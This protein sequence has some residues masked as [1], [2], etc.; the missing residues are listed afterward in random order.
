M[1]LRSLILAVLVVLIGACR[2]AALPLEN[3]GPRPQT[4]RTD[5]S[6]PGAIDSIVASL[7]IE[8]KVAQMIAVRAYGHFINVDSDPFRRLA[9]L[10]A[11]KKIGGIVMAQG[12]VYEEAMLVNRLQRLAPIPLLIGAD[13]ER[14][15][16]MR[17]RRGTSFPDAMAVGATR[18]PELAYRMGLA[19]AEEARAIG[20]H[21]NYAPVADINSNP[22]NPVINTRSFGD[23]PALVGAMVASFVKGTRDGGC[24]ATVKHFPGHG[25]TGSDSH[26]EL[27]TVNLSRGRLDSVEMSTFRTAIDS[28]AGSVMLAHLAVPALDSLRLPASLSRQMIDG[29][30]RGTMGFHGLAVTD[31]MG[32]QA[33]TRNFSPARAALLA[34]AAGIDMILVPPDEDVAFDAIVRAVKNGEIP[35]TRIDASVRRIL[36]TKQWLGLDRRRFVDPDS[37]ALCVGSRPHRALAKEICRDAVTLVRNSG[38]LLPLAMNGKDRVATVLISDTEENRSDVNRPGYPL[39]SEPYGQYFLQLLHRRSAGVEAIR[40]TPG[41]T[42]EECNAA[43]AQVRRADVALVGMFIKVHTASGRIGLPEGLSRFFLQMRETRTPVVLCLFGTPYL[44]TQFPEAKA[45]LCLYGDNEEQTE[46][47]AEALFGEIPL[48]GKLPVTLAPSMPAGTGI[49]LPQ[50]QLRRDD[51]A[52]AGF[53]SEE[54][55][56]LDDIV[57]QAIADSAFPGAQVAVIKDGMLVY[58]RWFGAQTYGEGAR[59]V[60]ATTMYDCASLTKVVATTAALMRLYDLKKFALDDPVGAYLPAFSRNG[61]SSVTIRHLLLHRGGFPPFRQLWKICPDPLSALDSV[62]AT[63]LVARPGDS[64]IYSDLGMITLGKLAEKLAGMPLDAFVRREFYEPLHMSSTM[65]RPDTA[66]RERIAPTEIDTSWRHRLIHG[67]VH[68]E[69]AAFLGGVSGH[70]G[71]FST[72]PDLAVFMQM[73]LNRGTYGGK[74]YISEGTWY[75]FLGRKSRGQERWLG[76]DMWSPQGSSAGSWFSPWSFGH[77]GFTGTSLWADPVRNLAVVFLTNRVY[78]SRAN[79]RLLKVRPALHDAVIHALQ[80]PLAEE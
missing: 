1:L 66:L 80:S 2:T 65:F 48:R 69:N 60:D 21:Q 39:T 40:L 27:P 6:A 31:A 41:S 53:S 72:A 9:H 52:V 45:I 50:S 38:N 77:T 12:D 23:D 13:F 34:A 35:L 26:L 54:L 43:L 10:V 51:P 37:I 62:Y 29:V 15:I 32:M 67:D 16:A 63:P 11:T 25:E 68:D 28:G 46:A 14:G 20:V 22:S 33:I 73:L 3:A 55:A 5:W 4:A 17:V 59:P 70:A 8:E 30:L 61:K 19:I 24:V 7:S 76:W 49:E 64:T 18:Q 57:E 79:L 78:P 71:L 36:L 47:A 58:A 75:E 44:A 74:R 56:H 42:A